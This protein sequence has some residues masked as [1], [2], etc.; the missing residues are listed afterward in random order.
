M[1]DLHFENRTWKR[2]LDFT[3]DELGYYRERLAEVANDW[4]DHD[5]LAMVEH[6][7]NTFIRQNEVVD[8]LLHTI[9][10]EELNLAKFAKDHPIAVD[11]V[12]FND[13]DALRDKVETQNHIYMETRKEFMNFL[14]QTM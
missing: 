9:K 6:F 8:Q 2:Q 13:H 10:E 3:K 12:Y 11:H 1:A 7:Q 4:T 14:R 5:V